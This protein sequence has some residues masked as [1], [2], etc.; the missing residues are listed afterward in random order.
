MRFVMALEPAS[1][2]RQWVPLLDGSEPSA[3]TLI[4]WAGFLS[5]DW[6]GKE[7]LPCVPR[8]KPGNP[9]GAE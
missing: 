9:G 2:P 6:M 7:G 3:E 8:R 5:L 1:R 4:P